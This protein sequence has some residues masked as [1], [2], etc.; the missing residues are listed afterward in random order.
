MGFKEYFLLKENPDDLYGS[1]G[2]NGS[3][4]IF[5]DSFISYSTNKELTHDQIM[6]LTKSFVL[7]KPLKTLFKSP[8]FVSHLNKE[9][10]SFHTVGEP[11]EN[12]INFFNKN[13][14]LNRTSILLDDGENIFL[15]R[16]D[17]NKKVMS[18]WNNVDS[19]SSSDKIIVKKVA[20]TYKIPYKELKY[21]FYVGYNQEDVVLTAEQFFK[22]SEVQKQKVDTSKFIHGLS[23]D[24]K[25]DALLQ[26]GAKPKAAKGVEARYLQGES[27][28]DFFQTVTESPDMTVKRFPDQETGSPIGWPESDARSFIIADDFICI[29]KRNTTWHHHMYPLIEDAFNHNDKK[30]RTNFI[31]HGTPSVAFLSQM[32]DGAERQKLVTKYPNWIQGRIWLEHKYISFWNHGINVRNNLPNISLMIQML[33]DDPENFTWELDNKDVLTFD[34]VKNT[35]NIDGELP[36]TKKDNSWQQQVHMLS[37]E[38]KGDAL[39]AMGV[40]PKAPMGAA[41]RYAMGESFKFKDFFKVISEKNYNYNIPQDKE[42]LLY[43]FYMLVHLTALEKEGKFEPG[44]KVDPYGQGVSTDTHPM[45]VRDS[46]KYSFEHIKQ[47]VIDHLQP[48]LLEAAFY[49]VSCEFRHL[50]DNNN[51]DTIDY[52]LGKDAA[53]FCS[54]FKYNFAKLQNKS[55]VNIDH[56]EVKQHVDNRRAQFNAKHNVK[57]KD[58]STKNASYTASYKAVKKSISDMNKGKSAYESMSESDFI[59]LAGK[60]F[61]QLRWN[62]SYGGAPWASICDAYTKLLHAKKETD[63]IIYIDNM[64]HQQHNTDTVF[65]KISS[66]CKNNSYSWVLNALNFKADVRDNWDRIKKIRSITAK[67]GISP[68]RDVDKMY[69]ELLKASGDRSYEQYFE[70]KKHNTD[71]DIPAAKFDKKGNALPP[72]DLS[73]LTS[74]PSIHTSNIKPDKISDDLIHQALAFAK[75]PFIDMGQVTGKQSSFLNSDKKIKSGK[76]I[77]VGQGSFINDASIN[78]GD[79]YIYNSDKEIWVLNSENHLPSI[80]AGDYYAISNNYWRKTFGEKAYK[81]LVPNFVNV[82]GLDGTFIHTC[83]KTALYPF[84]E[85]TDAGETLKDNLAIH[86]NPPVLMFIGYGG[87]LVHAILKET[88]DSIYE[89]NSKANEWK[90]IKDFKGITNDSY[91]AINRNTWADIFGYR[92]LENFYQEKNQLLKDKYG[93]IKEDGD[94]G[95]SSDDKEEAMKLAIIPFFHTEEHV[96]THSLLYD[97]PDISKFKL[98]YIGKGPDSLLNLMT[99]QNIDV[100]HYNGMESSWKPLTKNLQGAFASFKRFAIKQDDWIK[101]FGKDAFDLVKNKVAADGN[102]PEKGTLTKV[103]DDAVIEFATVR[104]SRPFKFSKMLN[105]V[106]GSS[107]IWNMNVV[108]VGTGMDLVTKANIPKENLYFFI[109]DRWTQKLKDEDDMDQVAKAV[110]DYDWI[111]LFGNDAW[112]KLKETVNSYKNDPLALQTSEGATAGYTPS[113]DNIHQAVDMA[114]APFVHADAWADLLKVEYINNAAVIYMGTGHFIRTATGL[115][116]P[117]KE[118]FNGY[119]IEVEYGANNNLVKPYRL[120]A[121]SLPVKD[122]GNGKYYAMPTEEWEK[123]FGKEALDKVLKEFSS[124]KTSMHKESFKHFFQ[125]MFTETPDRIRDKNNP[126]NWI[127]YDKNNESYTILLFTDE[128][129]G[130]FAIRKDSPKDGEAGHA[131]LKSLLRRIFRHNVEAHDNINNIKSDIPIDEIALKQNNRGSYEVRIWT[132]SK[133]ISFWNEWQ[134]NLVQPTLKLFK[135]LGQ[136]PEEYIFEMDSSYFDPREADS[137]GC[138]TYEEFVTGKKDHSSEALMLKK[139]RLEDRNLLAQAKLGMMN[140]DKALRHTDVKIKNLGKAPSF[141]K[142]SG[143]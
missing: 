71:K 136:N 31:M 119:E 6:A 123:I 116:I 79:V 23:G 52:K 50:F 112:F 114:T 108:Y 82:H 17:F 93:E 95:I 77:F 143:D 139:K 26:M 73:G 46:T 54:Y 34:Q 127:I 51:M 8:G 89:F 132:N 45:G 121:I 36:E 62:S 1:L 83:I 81:E 33:G 86:H 22:E 107:F 118:I 32:W 90:P 35:P 61:T 5:C 20:E 78:V 43:D 70:V 18:F 102:K 137:P 65:N 134:P 40:K 138:Y 66:Y 140:K 125:Q 57:I 42:L 76:L 104:G 2:Y 99:K 7:K 16:I 131:N 10:H 75:I 96:V 74:N 84:D 21:D 59:T 110:R 9:K 109:E 58:K 92:A 41:R 72:A 133:I 39:K 94:D 37:P 88:Q 53:K 63:K 64:Y 60:S 120:H 30:A 25:K 28:K 101:L 97:D 115:N 14:T 3:T 111:A 27:F 106:K 44:D 47:D 85:D 129:P 12:L 100:Y 105:D 69:V 67:N 126:D 29:T 11:S 91:Y 130:T 141:Y 15:G 98:I 128:E 19:F 49:S 80:G 122:L 38:K 87:L 103:T 135:F 13:K 117:E 68:L 124:Y 48:A 4:F 55:Q 113:K 24:K 56:P 142:N